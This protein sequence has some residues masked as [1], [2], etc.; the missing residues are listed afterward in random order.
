M[1]LTVLMAGFIFTLV[2]GMPI[3][4]G[5][6]VS[7]LVP[8]LMEGLP[9][10]LVPQKIASGANRFPFMC[11]PLFILA[12]E[13]MVKGGLTKGLLNL[14]VVVVGFI[15]G[16][17]SLASIVAAMIFSGISGSATADASALG[18]VEI[19]MMVENGYPRPFAGAV[20]ASAGV[21]GPMIPPSNQ[22][23]I[24]CMVV[25]GVSIG[26]LFMALAVPGVILGLCLMIAC[27]VS[28]VKR[29][30]PKR[31]YKVTVSDFLGALKNASLSLV[32]PIIILGGIISGVF[33]ATEA[34]AIAAVYSF[35]VAYFVS[36][37]LKLSDLPDIFLAAGKVAAV[38]LIIIATSNIFGTIIAYERVAQTLAAAVEP[39]GRLSFLLTVNV[40]F[41]IVGCFMD[42]APSMII[43]VP[44]LAPIAHNLGIAQLHFATII[45]FNLSVGMI[46]PPMGAILFVTAPLAKITLEELSR[47]IWPFVLEEVAVLLLMTY[48]PVF[49]LA[50]PKALGF[51]G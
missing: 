9:L 8:L 5:V 29:G 15:R 19:P 37:Q 34:A 33:T 6:A 51:L 2:I 13:F 24:Y 39:M 49:S 4:W 27:Y 25:S 36:R 30:Y 43:L 26:G 41:L 11:I 23:V 22:A 18:S 50:L 45:V 31:T 3:A 35:V 21:I 48:L 10:N 1:I 47:A 16:G 17:L 44:I 32:A 20:V 14:A 28:A 46:T 12:G 40:I 38:V 7:S 42:P